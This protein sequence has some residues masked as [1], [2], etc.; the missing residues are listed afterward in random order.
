MDGLFFS[1][2]VE[3]DHGAIHHRVKFEDGKSYIYRTLDKN[4]KLGSKVKVDG[5]MA[6]MVGEVVEEKPK[7]NRNADAF[8]ISE[9]ISY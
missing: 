2:L 6:G 1:A 3:K 5:K 7:F 4:L 9:V 8:Y